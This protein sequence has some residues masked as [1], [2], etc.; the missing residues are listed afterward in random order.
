MTD[1]PTRAEPRSAD[2]ERLWA[3][4]S[5]FGGLLWILPPL[6]IFLALKGRSP[7]VRQESKESLN[8]QITFTMGYV[9]LLVVASLLAA[10]LSLASFVDAARV[11]T[12][13]PFL[14]YVTNAVFCILGGLRVS[15]GGV[16]RYPFSIRLI[17]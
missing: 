7:L 5:H 12:T 3:C 15:A 16:Y 10:L 4:L 17:R 13:L 14:L 9:V 1:S 8:W 11:L 2:D 6:V